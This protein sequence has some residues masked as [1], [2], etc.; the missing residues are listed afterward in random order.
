MVANSN[1]KGLKIQRIS[2]ME[3][4]QKFN[5][6]LYWDRTKNGE[7]TKVVMSRHVPASSREPSGTE[8]Q[9]V[10]IRDSGG[11]EL[12]RVHLYLRPDNT[13]GA[14]GWPDP[15]IVLEGDTLYMQKKKH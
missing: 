14:S 10:S 13:L 4:R 2:E 11:Q 7:L 3:L 6:G 9:I 1:P 12:A 5:A 15:K 8:S